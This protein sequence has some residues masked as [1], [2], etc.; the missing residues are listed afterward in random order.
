[1]EQGENEI[2]L[3]GIL[4]TPLIVLCVIAV[5]MNIIRPFSEGRRYIKAE[6]RRAYNESEYR[7]WKRELKK[8]YISQIPIV[9][10]MIVRRMR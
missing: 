2:F 9:G 10:N 1:M 8:L 6:M 5:Y 3:Y 4:L 7:Y